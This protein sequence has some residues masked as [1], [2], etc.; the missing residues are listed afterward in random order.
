[1]A[2]A[3]AFAGGF[4]GR[5][6]RAAGEPLH[7]VTWSAAVDQVKSHLDGFT[8]KTGIPVDY[9]N[10]PWANYRETQVTKFVAGAP[11]DVLWVSD[12]WLPEWAD[13]GWLAPVDQHK[14]LTQYNGDV[15]EFCVNSMTYKDHQYGITYYSDNMGFFYNEEMLQKAGIAAP[16]QSWDEVTEQALKIKKAGLS[17]FPVLLALARETWLIEYLS[18]IVFSQ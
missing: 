9:S 3:G 17:E 11:I 6:A 5:M 16:P 8:R 13:A 14:E 15:T 18:T 12:S 10:T 7:F 1:G 4:L 2:A